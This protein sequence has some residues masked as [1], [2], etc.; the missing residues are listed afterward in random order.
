M[1]LS[2]PAALLRVE[3]VADLVHARCV[4]APKHPYLVH[5]LL[6]STAQTCP[7]HTAVYSY[8]KH[9]HQHPS[10]Q[11]QAASPAHIKTTRTHI[12]H[13]SNTGCWVLVAPNGP[14]HSRC[15]AARGWLPACLAS[16]HTSQHIATGHPPEAPL[17]HQ[18]LA[19]EPDA[20]NSPEPKRTTSPGRIPRVAH[21]RKRESTKRTNWPTKSSGGIRSHAHILRRQ[22]TPG[23]VSCHPCIGGLQAWAMRRTACRTW[24]ALGRIVGPIVGLRGI[25]APVAPLTGCTPAQ[26]AHPCTS[27]QHRPQHFDISIELHAPR[28]DGRPNTGVHATYPTSTIQRSTQYLA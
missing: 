25:D 9:T 23:S 7:T 5:H 4:L 13:T 20:D 22:Y 14:C 2:A 17:V 1:Q 18:V 24:H 16:L 6:G 15:L 27:H 26:T 10:A 8:S 3:M 28:R 19:A 12:I 11:M 21:H